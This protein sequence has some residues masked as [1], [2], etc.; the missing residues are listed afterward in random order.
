MSSSDMLDV[1]LGFLEGS[2]DILQEPPIMWMFG[3]YIGFL[4]LSFIRKLMHTKI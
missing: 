4:A 1:W 3:L 2:V